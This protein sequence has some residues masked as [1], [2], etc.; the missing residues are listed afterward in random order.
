MLLGN[1]EARSTDFAITSVNVPDRLDQRDMDDRKQVEEHSRL[2]SIDITAFRAWA[3]RLFLVALV[4]ALGFVVFEVIDAWRTSLSVAQ[5]S[6]RLSTALGVPVQIDSS[7]FGISPA[8]QLLFSKVEIANRV[9]LDEVSI[10]L[11]YRQLGEA[12]QGHGWNW[13]DAV[14]D[15]KPIT[16][17]QCLF[18]LGLLPKLDGAFPKTLSALRFRRLTISDQPWVAG[19]W[20]VSMS[21]GKASGM[22]A[23]S[24]TQV[25]AKGSVQV[26][27]TPAN[28]AGAYLFQLDGRN[29]KPPFGPSF[30]LEEIVANGQISPTRLDVDRYSLG[31]PFGAATGQISAVHGDSWKLTGTAD[32]EGIDLEALIRLI[33][34]TPNTDE[35][36]ALTP[37]V[38]QGTAS[39]QGHF[40]GEGKTLTDA[41][42]A[43]RF[44][45][46]VQVRS[47]VLTG[48]NLGY[49]AIR[50]SQAG[51]TSGGSTRFASLRTHLVSAGDTVVFRDINAHAGA[52]AATGQVE[53]KPDHSLTGHLHV[54]LGQTRVLAPIRVA[55]RGTVLKP[56]FGR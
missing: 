2:R 17:D 12:L 23:V 19:P 9:V 54:D 42:A 43:T 38:I 55:V 37:T 4:V 48:I 6:Q 1:S 8:P 26:D 25:V 22:A 33:A 21:R 20:D 24:A 35:N 39:V 41:V 36:S 40:E 28:Q 51:V 30:A 10:S 13:G 15:T 50:P 52:L 45:A 16:L 46:P 7:R 49:A 5:I 11:D 47:P 18:L 27:L 29:W 31:G 3:P 44:E 32:S 56:E 14:V 34:P 53:L